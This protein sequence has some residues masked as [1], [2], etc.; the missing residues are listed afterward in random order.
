MST[1]LLPPCFRSLQYVVLF[2]FEFVINM[3]FFII[4][5]FEIMI[6]RWKNQA[7]LV[8]I[9]FIK[10][11]FI[12]APPPSPCPLLTHPTL[13]PFKTAYLWADPQ[14]R[15]PSFPLASLIHIPRMLLLGQHLRF[16]DRIH[17]WKKC[18]KAKNTNIA[19]IVLQCILELNDVFRVNK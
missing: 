9:S 2:V 3:C 11:N 10:K 16:V 6:H 13:V 4:E 7:M 17:R 18:G 15:H 14:E 8:D 5:M 12:W 1:Y 19:L